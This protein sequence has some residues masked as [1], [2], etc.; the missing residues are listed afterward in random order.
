MPAAVCHTAITEKKL[1]SAPY[2]QLLPC[3]DNRLGL[4]AP[5]DDIE[6]RSEPQDRP[7]PQLRTTYVGARMDRLQVVGLVEPRRGRRAS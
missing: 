7:R 5:P 1:V 2:G 6:S 4:I 3:L